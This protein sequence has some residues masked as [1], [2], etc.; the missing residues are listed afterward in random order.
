[1]RIP[2]LVLLLG[3][4]CILLLGSVTASAEDWAPRTTLGI[5]GER[6]TVNG[7][8]VFLQGISAMDAIGKLDGEQLDWLKARGFNLIRVWPYW[9]QSLLDQHAPTARALERENLL[10]NEDGSV[11]PEKLQELR[12]L[13]KAADARGIVVDLTMFS[14]FACFVD[15]PD[16][17]IRRR[18]LQEV[19]RGIREFRNVLYDLVNEHNNYGFMTTH[20]DLRILRD[21]VK[22]VD[23][24]RIVTASNVH[25]AFGLKP[26]EEVLPFYIT[27]ITEVRLDVMTPHF[28]RTP[29][30]A[31]ETAG[32]L[33]LL[34]QALREEGIRVPIYLQEEARRRHSGLNPSLEEFLLSATSAKREGA[35]AWVFHTDAGYNL[36]ENSIHANMDEVEKRVA[37]A[38]ADALEEVPMPQADPAE[39]AGVAGL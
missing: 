14:T 21:A 16:L 35:A 18:A 27:E 3:L 9:V 22:E 26:L 11:R 4:V 36:S 31:S 7:E 19:T 2:I 34:R 30:F 39:E 37:D 12:D 5:E 20:P 10:W 33:R 25:G 32:R 23:P 28:V 6:F 29:D 24:E 17:T 38:L 8:A 1:M 15:D 13:L